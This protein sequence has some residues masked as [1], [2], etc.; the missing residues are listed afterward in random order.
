[1]KIFFKYKKETKNKFVFEQCDEMGT[2][3]P[4]QDSKIQGLYVRKDAVE[5]PVQFLTM[6]LERGIN[7]DTDND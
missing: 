2:S 4:P 6:T 1:M 7:V 3:V 5:Q